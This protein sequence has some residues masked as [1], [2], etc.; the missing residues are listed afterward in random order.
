MPSVN[1]HQHTEGSFLDGEA[2]PRRVFERAKEL[3]QD[4]VFFTDHGECNQHPNGFKLAKEFGMR[5][6]PGME[7]YYLTQG[8]INSAQ[9][10]KRYPYP[11]HITLLAAD[12]KG[13]SNLWALSSEC[14]SDPYFYYKPIATPDLLTKYSQGIWASDGCFSGSESFLAEDGTK[15]FAAT[16]GTSQR[17]LGV[18]GWTNAEIR[19]FG[20]QEIYELVVRRGKTTKKIATTDNHRWFTLNKRYETTSTYHERLT[21]N[22]AAGDVL[23]SRYRDQGRWRTEISPTGVQAGIVFGDGTVDMG[24]TGRRTAKVTLYGEKNFDLLKWF[25]LDKT[26]VRYRRSSHGVDEITV[27]NLPGFFKDS[28][29]LADASYGYLYGWLAGYFAADG[30]VT[31][32][33]ASILS[34]VRREHLQVASDICQILGI[35]VGLITSVSRVVNLNGSE[36]ESTLYNLCL[37]TRDLPEDFFLVTEHILRAQSAHA[38]KEKP[39]GDWRVVSVRATGRIEEVFCAV[40]ED[41]HAFALEGNIFTGNCMM[42]E[43]SDA[44]DK[45]QDDRAR[46]LLGQLHNI[47]RDRFY[48]ELHTWQYIQPITDEHRQL[49]ARMTKL[50]QAKVRFAHEMGIPMVVVNDSHHA[51]PEDWENKELVWQFNTGAK[52]DQLGEMAQKAD[53]L[54]G[55]DELYLYMRKHGIEDNVIAEAISYSNVIAESIKVDWQPTLGI[56]QMA[57]SERDDLV[58]L[59]SHCKEGF[60]QHVTDEGL[61]EPQYMAR[62]EEE[63]SLIA[64]KKFAGYFNMVRDYTMAYRSGSWSQY[65]KQ[66]GRKEPLLLGPARGSVGGSLVAYL[67]GIDIIDPIKYGT[68]FSR[69]LSPGRQG[70]PDIDV[71]V[72]QSQ[73]PDALKY[74]SA[75]FGHENVCAI[76]TLSRSGAKQTLRDLGKALQVPYSDINIMADHIAEVESFIDQDDFDAEDITWGDIVARKGGDLRPWALKYPRL[77]EKM[78]DMTKKIRHSGVHA[79]GVLVSSIPIMGAVPTRRTKNKVITTQFDM[80]EIEELGGVK[81]DLLGI[82]HLDTLSHARQLI[83]ERHGVWIDYDRSGL[84]VPQGYSHKVI[85]FGDE[86]FNDPAIWDQIDKGQTTGIFQVETPNCTESAILFKPRSEKDIADLTS[87]IRPGVADA[88]LKDVYLRRRAGTEP[89]VYDHPMMERIVGPSWVT[90]TYGVMVYQEQLMECVVQLAGFNAVDADGVRSAVGKKIMEKL[91]KYKDQ[92]INGCLANS[93]FT[94]YC[95]GPAEGDFDRKQALQIANHLWDSI[96]ASGRYA[97]NWSHAVGYAMIAAWEIWTKHYYPQEFLVALMAT[98][99]DNINKYIREAR[100]REVLILPPDVNHS[101]TKF[102]IEGE[103]IRYGIDTVRG[104]GAVACRHIAA[105]RPYTS[106]DD[107]LARSGRG[108]DKTAAYNL[109]VIGAFDSLVDSREDALYLLERQ[110]ILDDVSPTKLKKLTE[111][112]KDAIWADKRVRLA[113]KYEIEIPDFSDPKVVYKI[114]K[115][116]VGTYVTV[117]P[118]ER[119]IKALDGCALRDPID[120]SRYQPKDEFIVGGELVGISPTVTKKGKNPGAHM[121][122]LTIRWNEADFRVVAF[123]EAWARCKTLL[124]LEAPVACRVKK[125]DSGCCLESVERLDFLFDRNGIA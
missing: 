85:R 65:V 113:H 40:V 57:E 96:E 44:I 14:Y 110:R 25:P 79:A 109:A 8:A 12:N 45:D 26:S 88:G 52:E 19:S 101:D 105:G 58:N 77:F 64:D 28:P 23:R 16:V 106:F 80:W 74:L 1:T 90:N 5:F 124:E 22:L 34:S 56:P 54:M 100:R 108:A 24:R 121:A 62:L 82:R 42:T 125:L 75:R 36:R 46:Q 49:N 39:W 35:K 6:G 32:Q 11:S 86:Q 51:Y 103:A 87:I 67:L 66:G 94:W 2:R 3:G 84:S 59:I 7:G 41:G 63:L 107:Y 116:L 73:R 18:R 29:D 21:A 78:G 31:K 83:Y 122:H 72:P 13:L 120:M 111:A 61:N 119:Y 15:T 47:F 4:T 112:E 117:D 97:F 118:M 89:V 20:Q 37:R 53:H 81:L 99:S 93:D 43:F 38:R 95:G 76:G 10:D 30:C 102:T 60:R 92:F 50:N 91:L 114:E 98:D 9:E 48:I 27:R 33:G 123:P 70:L 71:D 17:V 69:F 104:L 68:L 55:D 115:E